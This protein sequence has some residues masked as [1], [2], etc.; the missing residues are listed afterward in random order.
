MS[1]LPIL[2]TPDRDIEF[3]LGSARLR[4]YRDGDQPS[5]MRHADD[6]GVA[7][8][9][10]D[11]FPH[12]YTAADA[13]S[14]VEHA[15]TALAGYVFAID[16]GGAV[17]GSVGLTPGSDV[18]AWSSEIG[19]WLGR[20]LWGRGLAPRALAALTDHAL[21]NMGYLRLFAGVFAG[22]ER[23]ARVL[24]KCG[25]HLESVRHAA[26]V[27]RGT[28]YDEAVWVRLAADHPAVLGRASWSAQGSGNE[29]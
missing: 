10:R 18:F 20:D 11:G 19:Y 17:V 27:K 7:R 8:W 2:Y 5:L 29:G 9:L 1:S 4:R 13:D 16:V 23:S 28:V 12:P 15:S 6:E 26:V 24:A 3:D 25:Y 14:W 22:N 21:R